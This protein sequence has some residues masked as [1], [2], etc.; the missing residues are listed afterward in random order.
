VWFLV[1]GEGKAE[2]VA[3]ARAS[4]GTVHATPARG[5]AGREETVWFLDQAAAARL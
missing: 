3:A 5:V 1:S 4:E 2:A